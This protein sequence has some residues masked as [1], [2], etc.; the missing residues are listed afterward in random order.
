MTVIN[1]EFGTLIHGRQNVQGTFDAD[2]DPDRC[3]QSTNA[4]LTVYLRVNFVRV[5]PTPASS[6][7]N[8]W[9]NT[10]VPI[11]AWTDG[12]WSLWKTRFMRDCNRK[13]NGKFWLVTPQTYNALN[14]P[15]SR[16]THRCNLYCRF[17][18]SEQANSEGAHAVIPVVRVNGNHNFRSDMLTYSDRD[19]RAERLT[20]GSLFYT[21]IHEIGHLMGL[22][23]PGTGNAGCM[24]GGENVCYAAP[25]GDTTGVMG[26]GSRIREGNAGPWIKAA[27]ALTGVRAADWTVRLQRARPSRI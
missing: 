10:P 13:W 21:H 22:D 2:L 8:D 1:F 16:P 27:A 7:Y 18:M 14:W 15:T 6:T 4:D 3:N 24:T 25:D 20:R 19:L 17:E 26:M 5:D 12:Q 11:R 9:D 23:H